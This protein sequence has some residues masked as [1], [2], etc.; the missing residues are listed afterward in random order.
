MVDLAKLAE[1]VEL[2]N[3]LPIHIKRD[4]NQSNELYYVLSSNKKRQPSIDKDSHQGSS[5]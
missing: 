2:Y 3:Y 1:I 4:K 5:E